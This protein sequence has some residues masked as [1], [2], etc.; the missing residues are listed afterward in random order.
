MCISFCQALLTPHLILATTMTG[1]AAGLISAG[2][3]EMPFRAVINK[4]CRRAV[5]PVPAQNS[6]HTHEGDQLG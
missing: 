3:M 2:D 1:G 6:S 4:K 5:P